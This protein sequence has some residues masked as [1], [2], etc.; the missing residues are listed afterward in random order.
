MT[1]HVNLPHRKILVRKGIRISTT[2]TISKQ[3]FVEA[4]CPMKKITLGKGHLST[5]FIILL[6]I[7]EQSYPCTDKF[8]V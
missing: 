6:P 2:S 4:K 8:Y 3:D 5:L 7:V 1:F